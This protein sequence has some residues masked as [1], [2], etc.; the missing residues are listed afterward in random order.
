MFII[1]KLLGAREC[2]SVVMKNVLKVD[3]KVGHA[4]EYGL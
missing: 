2:D 1:A 3:R 4:Q